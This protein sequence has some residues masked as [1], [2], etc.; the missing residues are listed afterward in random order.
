MPA[1][2]SNFP[3]AGDFQFSLRLGLTAFGG[4]GALIGLLERACG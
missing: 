1:L 3:L 4:P 2:T